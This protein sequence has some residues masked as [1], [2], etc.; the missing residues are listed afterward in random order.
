TRGAHG[1]L[2]VN[3]LQTNATTAVLL[4]S[5][6]RTGDAPQAPV[7]TRR[8]EEILQWIVEGKRNSEIATILGIAV[9]TVGKHVEHILEK[10]G[11]ETRT[12]AVRRWQD[13][14]PSRHPAVR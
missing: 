9:R 7:L 10:L 1:W 13:G 8:E 14:M 2:T 5:E 11:V 12:A 4:L 6:Q 3:L